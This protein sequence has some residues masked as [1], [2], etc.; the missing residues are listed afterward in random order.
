MAGALKRIHDL[1]RQVISVK[2][3]A[4]GDNKDA[5]SQALY[6]M[7]SSVR[8]NWGFSQLTGTTGYAPT[9]KQ[10]PYLRQIGGL[11]RRGGRFPCR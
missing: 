2:P 7:A 11:S 8:E 4:I 6:A 10:L 1:H 5:R 9:E 3:K